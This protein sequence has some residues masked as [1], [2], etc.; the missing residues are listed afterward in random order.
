MPPGL[1]LLFEV[2]GGSGGI[3]FIRVVRI[4]GLEIGLRSLGVSVYQGRDSE[5]LVQGLHGFRLSG[6]TAPGFR[7]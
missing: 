1:R 3:R 7:I 2:F 6:R 5:L 4:L